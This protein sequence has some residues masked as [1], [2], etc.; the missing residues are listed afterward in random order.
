MDTYKNSRHLVETDW[1]ETNLGLPEL[2]IFDCAAQPDPNTDEERRKKYPLIPRHARGHYEKSHIPGAAYIDVPGKLTDKMNEVPMMR[3]SIEQATEYF[4]S[5]GISNDSRVVLYSSTNPI[6]AART[7]WLLK[8]VGFDNAA[9]LNGGLAKW[10]AEKKQVSTDPSIYPSSQLETMQRP[11]FV[12][13]EQVLAAIDD[14]D[15]LLIHG[16]TPSV[17]DGSNDDLVFGRRGHIPKSINI[18]SQT[19]FDK[20]SGIYLPPARLHQ[21][22][23]TK[24]CSSVERFITYCG[25]GVNA[26]SVA[27]ALTLAGHGNVSIYDGSMNE[28]GNDNALPIELFDCR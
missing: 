26:S 19:L 13:K 10:I 12:D 18:P 24:D 15:T 5:V 1:L 27:F 22:F 4:S 28:W 14:D 25:G 9:I 6:W 11:V 7:W 3:P 16:L 23:E 8:A 20:N 2:R 21:L 17:Y